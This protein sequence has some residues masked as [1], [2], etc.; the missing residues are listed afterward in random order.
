[1]P[2]ERKEE[3]I[4][5]IYSGLRE[6]SKLSPPLFLVFINSMIIGLRAT[7]PGVLLAGVWIGALLYAAFLAIKSQS[8]RRRCSEFST[9]LRNGVQILIRTRT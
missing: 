2:G 1:M 4:Y 9:A 3:R 8:H 5:G 7:A 6:G